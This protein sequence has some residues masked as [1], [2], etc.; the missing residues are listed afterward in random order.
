[1][2]NATRSPS[3]QGMP[4]SKLVIV[5]TE[6]EAEA[7]VGAFGQFVEQLVKVEAGHNKI[8]ADKRRDVAPLGHFDQPLQVGPV[9]RD[10]PDLDGNTMG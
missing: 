10:I 5:I 7:D 8:A 9:V 4:C 6:P 1:M 3:F 2:E